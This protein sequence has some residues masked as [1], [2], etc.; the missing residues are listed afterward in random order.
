MDHLSQKLEATM[1]EPIRQ[2]AVQKVSGPQ[3]LQVRRFTTV[4]TSRKVKSN[5]NRLSKI[6]GREFVFPLL[7]RWYIHQQD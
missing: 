6:A 5:I 2:A 1:I 3:V 7:G 4:P